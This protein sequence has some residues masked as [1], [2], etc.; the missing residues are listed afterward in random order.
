MP[1]HRTVHDAEDLLA[2]SAVGL[3]REF[4]KRQNSDAEIGALKKFVTR[5]FVEHATPFGDFG[6][7]ALQ[8][9]R[10]ASP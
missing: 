9:K 7:Q 1:S 4:Q 3:S 6:A 8:S 2:L 10:R 5:N